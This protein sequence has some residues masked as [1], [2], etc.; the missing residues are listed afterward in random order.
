MGK[1][2]RRLVADT[3]FLVAVCNPHDA[4]HHD[5]AA[6]LT[7]L[8]ASPV[9]LVVSPLVFSETVTVLALRAHQDLARAAGELLYADPQ[10]LMLPTDEAFARQ[11]WKIYTAIDN[12]NVTPA[13]CSV[14]AA[15]QETHAG[16]VLT[17]D[18]ASFAPLQRAYDFTILTPDPQE[19]P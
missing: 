12:T 13:D 14:V 17:L 6:I 19:R 18:D 8:D 5:A 11:T 2:P 3:S 4:H 16:G 15:L 9:Q 1:I 10:V 7:Q